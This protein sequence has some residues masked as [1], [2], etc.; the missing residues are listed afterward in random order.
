MKKWLIWM[1]IVLILLLAMSFGIYYS[2]QTLNEENKKEI[3][4]EGSKD[5]GQK[6]GEATDT[7]SFDNLKLNPFEKNEN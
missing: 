7:N 3:N 5:I 2:Q 1:I 4:F 6:V